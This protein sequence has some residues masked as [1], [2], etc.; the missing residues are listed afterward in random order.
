[1]IQVKI[2]VFAVLK[3]YFNTEFELS[4]EFSNILDVEK[5]LL[6][7][8]PTCS[9]ILRVSRYAIDNT[10]ISDKTHFIKDNDL[11]FVFP[12]SSGG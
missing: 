8:V 10:I 1:M 6:E 2:K 11:I 7:K 5:A 3:D 9:P 12:P 4:G